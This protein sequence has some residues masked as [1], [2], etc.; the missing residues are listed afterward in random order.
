MIYLQIYRPTFVEADVATRAR[1]YRASTACRPNAT[2]RMRSK[3][4]C[5]SVKRVHCDKTKYSTAKILVPYKRF[6]HLVFQQK[7]WLVGTTLIPEIL[8][9]LAPF[10]KKR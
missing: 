1:F 6:V 9:Q 2:P 7:E 8:G 10:V 4:V 3:S 5:L